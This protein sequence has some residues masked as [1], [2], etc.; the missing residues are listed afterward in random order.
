LLEQQLSRNNNTHDEKGMTQTKGVIGVVKLK[1]QIKAKPIKFPS[2]GNWSDETVGVSEPGAQN[3]N[4]SDQ[5]LT[6]THPSVD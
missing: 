3:L 2:R 4:R 6:G 5:S 1:P